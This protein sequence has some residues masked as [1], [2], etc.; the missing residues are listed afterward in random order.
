MSQRVQRALYQIVVAGMEGLPEPENDELV[1]RQLIY[2]YTDRDR[3]ECSA[4]PP[5]SRLAFGR[6]ILFVLPIGYA[7]ANAGICRSP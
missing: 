2:I 7:K 1:C 5:C 6:W 3:R 4:T